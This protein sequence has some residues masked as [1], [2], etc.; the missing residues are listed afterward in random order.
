MTCQEATHPLDEI[1]SKFAGQKKESIHQLPS[2]GSLSGS[3]WYLGSDILAGEGALDEVLER[4]GTRWRTESPFLRAALLLPYYTGPIVS[5]V[6]NGL[7]AGRRVPDVSAENCAVRLDDAGDIAGY[8]IRSRRFA[9]LSSD[10]ASTHPDAIPVPNLES[11]LAWLFDCMLDRHLQPL[12]SLVRAKVR[13]NENVMWAGIAGSC[14]SVIMGLQKAG[15]FTIEE[16]IVA[17]TA[18]LDH[19]PLPMRDC[20]SVYPLESGDLRALFMRLE[21]CCQKYLHPDLGKCGYCGLR[22]VPEQ[23]ALQQSFLDR[24]VAENK[25]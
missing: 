22:P 1:F 18:L 11:L 15:Y 20:V 10:R 4:F 19:G 6:I 2:F 12:F 23:L 3:G 9:A 13:L 7:Y 8:A 25:P 17:K 21:I 5:A 24:Q 16:A 14:A